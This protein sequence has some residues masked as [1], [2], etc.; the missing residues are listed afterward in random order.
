MVYAVLENMLKLSSTVKLWFHVRA[1]YDLVHKYD[2]HGKD[3][4][5]NPIVFPPSLDI[6][7]PSFPGHKKTPTAGVG[8]LGPCLVMSLAL[9]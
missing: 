3:R 5:Y 1:K 8:V 9:S 6:T 4:S 2:Q 7:A